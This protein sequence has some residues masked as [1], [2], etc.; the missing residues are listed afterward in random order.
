MI[1]QSSYP[2]RPV[3]AVGIMFLILSVYVAISFSFLDD[4]PP[5][6]WPLAFGYCALLSAWAVGIARLGRRA[7]L[8]LTALA[9]VPIVLGFVG[10]ELML[11]MGSSLDSGDI[12]LR[13]SLYLFYALGVAALV[14]STIGWILY[15]RQ[16]RERITPLCQLRLE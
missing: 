1:Q 3:R 15:W 10:V 9:S 2:K 13:I 7:I 6:A 5:Q 16:R 14:L 8:L 12:W 11:R 4:F